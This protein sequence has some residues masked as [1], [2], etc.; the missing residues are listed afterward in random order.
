MA[1]LVKKAEELLKDKDRL[2]REPGLEQQLQ[3][4]V[5]RWKDGKLAI[6]DVVTLVR[7]AGLEVYLAQPMFWARAYVA[8]A[9]DR[10]A[11]RPPAVGA[12]GQPGREHE[13]LPSPQR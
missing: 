2:A 7:L 8:G 13:V 4:L 12:E 5:E 1:E 9:A 6:V 3:G 11:R 10:D